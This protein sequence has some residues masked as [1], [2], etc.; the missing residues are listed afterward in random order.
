MFNKKEETPL[1]LATQYGRLEA[2]ELLLDTRPELLEKIPETRSLLHLAA[3]NGH[4]K[5]VKVLLDKGCDINKR[6]GV[7]HTQIPLT[8]YVG[9]I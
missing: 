9:L 2:V 6:V 5:V 4:H 1:D 3:R 7:V 8:G